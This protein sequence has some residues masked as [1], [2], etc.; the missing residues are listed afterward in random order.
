MSKRIHSHFTHGTLNEAIAESRASEPDDV[1]EGLSEV[2]EVVTRAAAMLLHAINADS[3]LIVV[4]QGESVACAHYGD[5]PT[6][7]L[8][9]GIREIAND[10][11][12]KIQ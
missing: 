2:G 4:V 3:V 10:L 7:F 6:P 5:A 9:D 1:P 12:S 11:Q 8:I